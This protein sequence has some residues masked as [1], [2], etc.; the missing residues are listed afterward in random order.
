V[1]LRDQRILDAAIEVLGARGARHLTHRAVDAAA[2]LPLGSTSN[3]YRTRAALMVGV[4]Q[5]M[6]QREGEKWSAMAI[7]LRSSTIDAFAHAVGQLLQE[8]ATEE[9]TLSLARRAVF[10]EAAREPALADELRRAQDDVMSWLSP[11]L[12]ELGSAD[13]QH[14]ARYLMALMDGLV[15]HQLANPQPDFNPASALAALLRGLIAGD[16]ATK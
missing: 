10:I 3:R 7:D 4:L 12:V 16:R 6:L 11:A 1:E 5:R 13:P 9:R 2:G 15:G 14:H 8:L